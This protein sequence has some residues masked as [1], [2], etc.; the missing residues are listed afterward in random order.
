MWESHLG[1]APHRHPSKRQLPH[2]PCP[3][4]GKAAPENLSIHPKSPAAAP[5]R[6]GSAHFAFRTARYLQTRGMRSLHFV[7]MMQRGKYGRA[8]EADAK[9]QGSTEQRHATGIDG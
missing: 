8:Y 5:S 4:R 1:A 6:I 9:I 7:M 2:V 3:R